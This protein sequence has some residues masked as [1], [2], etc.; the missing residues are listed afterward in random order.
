MPPKKVV[1][2]QQIIDTAVEI[3]RRK[4]FGA[5]TARSVAS[6]LGI[7]THPL[8]SYYSSIDELKGDVL[9]YARGVYHDYI[10]RG[11][12]EKIPFLG[13]GRSF[14]SLARKEPEL[15]KLLFMTEPELS[16]S[17]A[18]NEFEKTLDLVIDSIMKI[19]GMD[20]FTASCY[21]RNLWLMTLSFATLIVTN[22]CPFS[23]EQISGIL[24]E[25]SLSLCK[26]YKEIPG[27]AKGEFDR[28]KIFTELVNK[29]PG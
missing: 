14:L 10:Q 17:S 27:F 26:S 23:D 15:F 20:R 25:I 24:T 11:L 21:Y 6:G 2:K 5:I 29:T 16:G 4:G 9:I 3:T 1:T 28:D 13:I 22:D 12:K 8:F 19:Y 18:M 7:S